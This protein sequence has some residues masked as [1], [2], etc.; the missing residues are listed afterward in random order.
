M[1]WDVG[2]SSRL[3]IFDMGDVVSRNPDV[4]PPIAGRL[5]LEPGELT[6][7]LEPEMSLHAAGRITER[8]FWERLGERMGRPVAED[9]LGVYFRPVLDPDVVRLIGGLRKLG[10][11]VCGTNTIQSHYDIHEKQGDYRCFDAVY[12]SHHMGLV[13]PDPEF[14]HHILRAE[15]ARPEDTVF[16]DDREANVAAA[17]ALG[18]R[19]L[20]FTGAPALEA[21][22]AA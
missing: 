10:R 15:G 19:A 17:R 4:F 11:V 2:T 7:M 16:V 8:V 18:I 14:F 6:R 20:V 21:W 3:Y 5:G 1:V 13:K 12:A 22:L 9:L